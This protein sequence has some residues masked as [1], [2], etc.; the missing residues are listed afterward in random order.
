MQKLPKYRVEAR[1][2]KRGSAFAVLRTG[3]RGGEKVV[4]VY[5]NELTAN[6]VATMLDSRSMTE[7]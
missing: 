2:T 7:V 6:R 5:A 4:T 1:V 3:P